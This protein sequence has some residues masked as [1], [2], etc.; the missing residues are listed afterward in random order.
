MVL[1]PPAQPLAPSLSA[2]GVMRLVPATNPVGPGHV[3]RVPGSVLLPDASPVEQGLAW[4]FPQLASRPLHPAL[5]REHLQQAWAWAFGAAMH[6]AIIS[7]C[8]PNAS[9]EQAVDSVFTRVRSLLDIGAPDLDVSQIAALMEQRVDVFGPSDEA[10]F[11]AWRWG[12]EAEFTLGNALGPDAWAASTAEM[13]RYRSREDMR[14]LTGNEL[15]AR[16]DQLV[17]V[18]MANPFDIAAVWRG[19]PTSAHRQADAA[20]KAR[21]QAVVSQSVTAWRALQNHRDRK[22][23]R[24]AAGAAARSEAALGEYRQARA[25]QM[26]RRNG[27]F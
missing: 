7:A 19:E 3:P 27:F 4:L 16:V 9:V 25:A 20:R 11:L 26:R 17:G 21:N 15:R 23:Y 10:Q 13:V 6:R 2:D 22:A 18:Y 1:P 24:R 8:G 12:C 5:V 14:L